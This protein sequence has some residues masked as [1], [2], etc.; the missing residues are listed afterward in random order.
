MR[1]R[2]LGNSGLK[3]AELC[4]GTMTFGEESGF[5]ADEAACRKVF[6]AYLAAGGNCIDTANIY[7]VGTSERML[8]QMIAAERRRLVVATRFSMITDPKDPNAGGNS[9]KNLQ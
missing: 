6:D 4:L 5:G 7:T 3:V 8:S 9:R 1:F 2:Q